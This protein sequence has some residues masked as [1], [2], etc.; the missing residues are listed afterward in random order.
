MAPERLSEAQVAEIL[1]Y[2]PAIPAALDI[3]SENATNEIK[4]KI[5]LQL[6]E[7]ALEHSKISAL[8][9]IINSL[10]YRSLLQPGEAVGIR[11]GEAIGQQLTQTGLSSF[12]FAG[13]V[14][15]ISSGIEAFREI[16]NASQNRKREVSSIHFINKDLTFEQVVELRR[17]IVGLTLADIVDRHAFPTNEDYPEFYEAY[18]Q[19]FG[20]F[21]LSKIFLRLYLN[22]RVMFEHKISTYAV[23]KVVSERSSGCVFCVPSPNNRAEPIVDIHPIDQRIR[24]CLM[25][26][27]SSADQDLLSNLIEST[28]SAGNAS[29]LFLNNAI[30]LN[31]GEGAIK[32]VS[33]ITSLYPVVSNVWS[34][35]RDE[36]RLDD[37]RYPYRLWL[38]TIFMRVNG[39]THAKLY[40]LLRACGIAYEAGPHTEYIDVLCPHELAYHEILILEDSNAKLP[41]LM[42]GLY[43]GALINAARE[44]LAA[45]SRDKDSSRFELKTFKYAGV[46]NDLNACQNL[47]QRS[48]YV[49]AQAEGTNL[50]A[51]LGLDFVD[52][53]CTICNNM[54]EIAR[55]LGIEACRNYIAYEIHRM[56]TSSNITVSPRFMNMIADFMTNMGNVTPITSRGVARQRRGVFADASFEQPIEFLKRAAMA[57]DFEKV[58]STS[59]CIFFGKRAYFGTGSFRLVLNN[60]F[61]G[62]MRQ[63]STYFDARIL[64]VEAAESDESSAFITPVPSQFAAHMQ[65]PI[66]LPN[67]KMPPPTILQ[68]EYPIPSWV[69]NVLRQTMPTVADL[70]RQPLATPREPATLRV[71]LNL[72]K[73]TA[74]SLDDFFAPREP[75]D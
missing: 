6:R 32:G 7:I 14:S 1:A 66:L 35:V 59:S 68:S 37:E 34:A 18:G 5:G 13:L 24:Q 30:V 17:E 49:W 75:K 53:T 70:L 19:I 71:N 38:D 41:K 12:H 61:R 42:P 28:T 58:E 47:I 29:L 26:D 51:L 8:G 50:K 69:G 54:H 11:T 15:A 40:G 62:P 73:S 60:Y 44:Q 67:P 31:L 74:T 57:G 52:T 45:S 2:I 27:Y 46:L 36:S 21:D 65:K 43:V 56:L 9:Q 16:F 64:A 48:Q 3:V 63:S 55:A 23:A 33:R 25:K 72:E 10:F 39:I 20:P 4:R 22:R